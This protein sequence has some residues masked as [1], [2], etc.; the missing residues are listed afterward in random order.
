MLLF[1]FDESFS[2][3]EAP[4]GFRGGR[5][6]ISLFA[7]TG[8]WRLARR[9]ERALLK[10]GLKQV[11]ALNSARLVEREIEAICRELPKWS[12]ERGDSRIRDVSVRRFFMTSEDGMSGFWLGPISE[13]N[14]LKTDTFL[15]LAQALAVQGELRTGK[16]DG[17]AVAVKNGNLH[18]SIRRMADAFSVPFHVVEKPGTL[19]VQNMRSLLPGMLSLALAGWLQ[20]CWKAMLAKAVMGFSRRREIS[21]PPPCSSAIF[22]I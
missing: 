16:Y 13:K 14:P 8:N 7:L 19:A 3:E 11:A 2:D 15:R 1:V 18:K 22:H 4:D 10:R 9:L 21:T 12:A 20:A 6:S 17:V 5:D